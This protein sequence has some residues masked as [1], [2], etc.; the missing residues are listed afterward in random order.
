M[1]AEQ[2]TL[3]GQRKE[4]PLVSVPWL[5]EMQRA[6]LFY[7]RTRESVRSYEIGMLYHRARP[8][9]CV[10][11]GK[12]KACCDW[13]AP[14]GWRAMSRLERRGLVVHIGRGRWQ[15]TMPPEENWHGSTRLTDAE[16]EEIVRLYA[17]GMSQTAIAQRLFRSTSTI[18]VV[19]R[20]QGVKTRPRL[21]A[22]R[23]LPGPEILRTVE[24]YGRG[25]SVNEVAAIL[26]ISN[27][28][29]LY[30]IKTYARD[31]VRK[32]AEARRVPR[33]RRRKAGVAAAP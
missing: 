27:G 17:G 6:I 5:T 26:G 31:G 9:G 28:A 19:L 20:R 13:A 15:A 11:G 25:Y 29:A 24:L 4:Y 30:R 10:G 22:H 2:L 21:N 3:D 7:V 33:E 23:L 1:S 12:G 32:G 16:V 14:D 8:S 18:C